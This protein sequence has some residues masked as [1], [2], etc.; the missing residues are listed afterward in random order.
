MSLLNICFFFLVLWSRV[1]CRGFSLCCSKRPLW[2]LHLLLYMLFL[3]F[4]PMNLDVC[5]RFFFYLLNICKSAVWRQR[6]DFRFRNVA[7]GAAQLIACIRARLRFYRPLSLKRFSSA[8]RRGF[9]LRQWGANGVL[10]S[11]CVS[12]FYSCILSTSFGENLYANLS[13]LR[14]FFLIFFFIYLNTVLTLLTIHRYLHYY[15]YAQKLS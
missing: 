7:P 1:V 4:L 6:N 9:F 15:C 13:L 14:F 5:R 11:V 8:G 12:R 2:R 10:S 3:V